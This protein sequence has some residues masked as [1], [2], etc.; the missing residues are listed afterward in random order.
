MTC[1]SAV[2]ANGEVSPVKTLLL[3][4]DAQ[5]ANLDRLYAG[6]QAASADCTVVR[7]SKAQQL[8]LAATLPALNYREFARIVIFS[9][10]KRLRSQVGF[11]RT[12][13]GLVF[14]EHDACQN[15]MEK[16]KYRGA[17]TTFYKKLPWVRVLVS[18]GTVA[19][20]LREEGV[21]AVFISKGYDETLIH[22]AEVHRDIHAAFLG[23]LNH[24][25]Y[26]ARSAMLEAIAGRTHLLITR[27]A[28]G[29]EYAAMLARIRVFVSADVGMDEY[30]IKNFEAMAAGCV[31]LAYDQGR[32]ENDA[33]GFV[34]GENCVLYRTAA[35][36]VAKLERLQA[37][38]QQAD[39]IAL[40]GRLM[41]EEKYTFTAVGRALARH[42]EAPMRAWP[43]LSA[44]QRFWAR[45]R[46]G[47]RV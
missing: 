25:A 27:T 10:L 29:A 9:R 13:P 30:M 47:V 46:W 15:Y 6:I 17:Y 4:M 14:I 3:V 1:G 42:I 34:D 33:L 36:A 44:C 8:H 24:A 18:S 11:L 2:T 23:S 39:S 16:S 22:A 38:P 26:A 28:S 41:V 12:I 35:E 32:E 31:L 37:C 7:L 21:D 40:A 45:V 5:R 19:R 43:G 20:R